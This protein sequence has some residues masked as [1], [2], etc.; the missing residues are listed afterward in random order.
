MVRT[1]VLPAVRSMAVV[2]L[3]G[4]PSRAQWARQALF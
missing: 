2:A 3:M 4:I 1:L